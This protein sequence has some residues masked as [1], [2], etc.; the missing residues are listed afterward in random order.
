MKLRIEID[1]IAREPGEVEAPTNAR[2]MHSVFGSTNAAPLHGPAGV[3]DDG[4]IPDAERLLQTVARVIGSSRKAGITRENLF[5]VDLK[6]HEDNI[7]GRVVLVE[8]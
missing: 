1:L 8:E 5:P 4:K 6:D 7:I 3:A 2:P